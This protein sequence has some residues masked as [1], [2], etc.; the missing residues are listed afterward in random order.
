MA[1]RSPPKV[2]KAPRLPRL[3]SLLDRK[4]YKTGQTRG[5]DDD[6]IFQN[7]VSRS[8]TVLIP[9]PVW[10]R[11][12][13]RAAAEGMYERGYIVLIS[14]TDY[15]GQLQNSTE[16]ADNGLVLG[17]NALVFYETRSQW[18]ANNP[19]TLRW[20][21]AESRLNPLR[22]QYVARI[23]ATTAIDT[24]GKIIRGFETTTN[25]GAGIRV[26]EYAGEAAIGQ[27]RN[28]LEALFWL[29]EDSEAVAASNGMTAVDAAL[30]KGEILK[31]CEGSGLLDRPRLVEARI[32]NSHGRTTCPLCLMELSSLGFFTRMEQAIGREVLD[33]TI[34]QINLF[35]I[36]ELRMGVFN[37]RPYNLG[38]G[39]HHCNVVVKD[40]GIRETLEWMDAVLKRNIEG[41]HFPPAV[42][43][44]NKGN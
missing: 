18:T 29:C 27:C 15:F 6:E 2:P 12:F 19:E 44:A 40:A 3:P 14:P 24:G 34:T 32:L 25:K 36:E 21:P 39:H 42:P 28:Q 38:W 26:Y 9:Y 33:L 16:L 20:Q 4:I 10:V 31:A 41:G 11:H 35:H 43:A 22:G 1:R 23:S 5:A 37:H 13:T 17:E 30:R 8:S 7:R